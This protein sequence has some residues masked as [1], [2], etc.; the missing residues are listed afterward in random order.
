MNK[1]NINSKKET[2]LLAIFISAVFGLT[3]WYMTEQHERLDYYL[4]LFGTDLGENKRILAR[5]I[6]KDGFL[7]SRPKFKI[8]SKKREGYVFSFEGRIKN[9]DLEIGNGE[10]SFPIKWNNL[11]NNSKKK[12]HVYNFTEKE[13]NNSF[14]LRNASKIGKREIFLLPE[15]FRI[16]PE[17]K[18]KVYLFCFEESK[19]CPD[20]P[21]S[22]GRERV[23]LKNGVAE[24]EMTSPP[25]GQIKIAF[26]GVGDI[27]AAFP[28]TGK[29]FNIERRGV[30][31]IL[32]S[33]IDHREVYLDC[34]NRGAWQYSELVAT[35]AN[36]GVLPERYDKCDRIQVSF[37]SYDPG[38]TFF[39]Y[40]EE[41]A[42]TISISDPYYT[43]L[44]ENLES[45]LPNW[46]GRVLE[47][48]NRSTFYG[49][50]ML[51][52][53]VDYEKD[54]NEV[55]RKK[56]N[57]IWWIF[58]FVSVAGFVY[59]LVFMLRR[60]SVIKDEDGE[61]LTL[62]LRKQRFVIVITSSIIFLFLFL[63]LYLFRSIS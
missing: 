61:L 30:K 5:V 10:I 41:P 15:S 9:I 14:S 62:S 40:S 58:L 1:E 3:V 57:S 36:G 26:D 33:L 59:F 46:R 28:F 21:V 17:F 56:L 20:G 43:R 35:S 50:T 42:G 2:V 47:I 22:V 38:S 51:Y 4:Y 34:Y 37:Y 60:T 31:K 53:G 44:Y 32:Y 12:G 24:I 45:L 55:K 16:I 54:Y 39:V 52:S 18:T 63:L 13:I 49:L 8:N 23:E 27:Y 6:T 7:L 29:M 25:E 48:Y 19:L 11:W